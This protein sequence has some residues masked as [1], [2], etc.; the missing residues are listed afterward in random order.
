MTPLMQKRYDIIIH[1]MKQYGIEFGDNIFIGLWDLAGNI[2]NI[3]KAKHFVDPE[4]HQSAYREY[5]FTNKLALNSW[6]I[7]MLFR[8][9][10]HTING[11]AGEHPIELR[12][13]Y[14][15]KSEYLIYWTRGN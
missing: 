8:G 4:K 13:S 12:K 7:Y 15:N 10:R 1:T 14:N 3:W 11:V 5:G 9:I 6:K 2:N